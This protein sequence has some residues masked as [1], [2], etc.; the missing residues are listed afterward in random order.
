MSLTHQEY[1]LVAHLVERSLRMREVRV[2]ITRKSISFFFYFFVSPYHIFLFW[3]VY[4]IAYTFIDNLS[5]KQPKNYNKNHRIG[6]LNIIRSSSSPLP[7][8]LKTTR[9]CRQIRLPLPIY[10]LTPVP[11]ETFFFWL[12]RST[13]FSGVGFPHPPVPVLLSAAK[14]RSISSRP[15]H[16]LSCAFLIFRHQS[17]Y[18]FSVSHK[19][20]NPPP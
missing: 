18:L 9:Q 1:G 11:K 7:E 17:R 19:S 3:K 16:S 20:I 8:P 2:S 13:I 5:A 10:S 15:I 14:K 4:T 6:L 12:S